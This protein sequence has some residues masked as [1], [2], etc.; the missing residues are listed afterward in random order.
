MEKQPIEI[1]NLAGLCFAGWLAS[2]QGAGEEEAGSTPARPASGT[3]RTPFFITP[4]PLIKRRGN[5]PRRAKR[6]R[7]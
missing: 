4:E 5:A 3:S 7:I 1:I 6:G 2:S